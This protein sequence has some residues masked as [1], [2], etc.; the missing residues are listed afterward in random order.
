M[1][2]AR[3]WKIK[4]NISAIMKERYIFSKRGNNTNDKIVSS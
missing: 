3:L 2:L 1:I 4:K